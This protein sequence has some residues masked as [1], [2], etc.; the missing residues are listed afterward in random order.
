MILKSILSP[1]SRTFFTVL[2]IVLMV[3]G[4][5]RYF[6]YVQGSIGDN[7]A[8]LTYNVGYHLVADSSKDENSFIENLLTEDLKILNLC[9]NGYEVDKKR[10]S[11]HSDYH[12]D[13]HCLKQ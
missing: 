6:H 10:R 11:R 3:S 9:S 1:N 4:C 12:W 5:T 7:R 13:F 8:V 2:F